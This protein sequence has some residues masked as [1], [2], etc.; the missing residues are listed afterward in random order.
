MK[1]TIRGENIQPSEALREHAQ[2]CVLLALSRF[3]RHVTS[4]LVQLRVHTGRTGQK[5]CVLNI[6]TRWRCTLRI[7]E[8]GRDLFWAIERAVE[9]A[10]RECQRKARLANAT[11]Q[12]SQ[13]RNTTMDRADCMAGAGSSS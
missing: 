10:G 1:I 4:T 12:V 2:R 3:G 8:E 13:I 9:R 11:S 7:V 5:E 6:R